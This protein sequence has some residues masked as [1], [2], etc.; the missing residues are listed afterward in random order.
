MGEKIQDQMNLGGFENWGYDV[1]TTLNYVEKLR[2]MYFQ[3][4]LQ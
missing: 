2:S 3:I 4:V 1:N